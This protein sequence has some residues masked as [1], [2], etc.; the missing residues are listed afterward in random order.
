M[1][2]RLEIKLASV[3]E[4]STVAAAL[5]GLQVGDATPASVSARAIAPK[6]RTTV[7]HELD[8]EVIG[9]DEM[10]EVESPFTAAAP[11]SEGRKEAPADKPAAPAAKVKAPTAA[12]K[13]AQEKEAKKAKED[14]ER[15]DRVQRLKD[16]MEA[17]KGPA[18]QALDN[19]AANL[20]NAAQESHHPV[21]PVESIV[22]EI[23]Q[24]GDKLMAFTGVDL[25]AKQKLTA[26]IMLKVG[27][28]AGVRP[29]QLQQPMLGQFRDLYRSS[30]NNTVNPVMGGLV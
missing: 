26:D 17:Q 16:Q 2:L 14:A 11:A 15:A 6:V 30:V 10:I 18:T 22:E 20:A 4:L 25:P 3:E 29:T 8:N 27:V 5:A 21:E 7:T 19:R 1:E 13:K 12:E 23:K 28:P 24:L 9:V